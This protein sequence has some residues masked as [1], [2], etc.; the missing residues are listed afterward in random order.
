MNSESNCTT[1]LFLTRRPGISRFLKNHEPLHAQLE[2]ARIK[3]IDGSEPLGDIVHLFSNA[4]HVAGYH[5]AI[6]V[7]TLFCGKSTL[8][9]YF[10]HLEI[11]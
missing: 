10:V 1:K 6:F 9:F 11:P 7:N 2:D 5:G 3:I 8:S 4:S